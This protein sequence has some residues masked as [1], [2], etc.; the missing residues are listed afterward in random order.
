MSVANILERNVLHV[1]TIEEATQRIVEDY[2][3]GVLRGQD[4]VFAALWNHPTPSS[5]SF[6][7]THGVVGCVDVE[8]RNSMQSPRGVPTVPGMPSHLHLQNMLVHDSVQPKGI[9]MALLQEVDRYAKTH[10]DAQ[11]LTV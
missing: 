11:M 2:E 8:L 5:S 10:T 7:S 3:E 9:E 4:V 6:T 1:P